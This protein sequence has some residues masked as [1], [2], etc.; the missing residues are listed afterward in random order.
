MRT[1][2][3]NFDPAVFIDFADNGNHFGCANVQTDDQILVSTLDHSAFP[4]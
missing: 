3:D 2:T 1:D 4:D